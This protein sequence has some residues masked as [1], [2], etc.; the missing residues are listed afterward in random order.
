MLRAAFQA[1]MAQPS[2]RLKAVSTGTPSTTPVTVAFWG[3]PFCWV[4]ANAAVG[5][6]GLSSAAL[7]FN[8]AQAA[9]A[10]G[11]LLSAAGTPARHTRV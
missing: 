3:P 7:A 10:V 2:L 11:W 4:Q 6:G 8:A 9:W 1:P 5:F